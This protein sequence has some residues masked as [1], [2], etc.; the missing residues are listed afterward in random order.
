MTYTYSH[1]IEAATYATDHSLLAYRDD[2]MDY[3]G[4]DLDYI[5]GE[6][7][8]FIKTEAHAPVQLDPSTSPN[9]ETNKYMITS[10]MIAALI[11]SEDGPV[12]LSVM[13]PNYRQRKWMN[14]N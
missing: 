10:N 8:A 6:F 2:Y 14:N 7:I 5:Y 9:G 1:L 11:M 13:T 3:D 4:D 12:L